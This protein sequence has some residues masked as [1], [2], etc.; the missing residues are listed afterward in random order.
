[1]QIRRIT[2][3]GSVVSRVRALHPDAAPHA[4]EATDGVR[5]SGLA[6]SQPA[7]RNGD[8]VEIWLDARSLAV[9]DAVRGD[10]SAD[11]AAILEDAARYAGRA[12]PSTQPTMPT[13]RRPRRT[14]PPRWPP[15]ATRASPPRPR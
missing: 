2:N 15:P 13:A 11:E 10:R 6:E 4:W 5:L 8:I 3:E 1:M 9:I 14:R 7:G 12:P